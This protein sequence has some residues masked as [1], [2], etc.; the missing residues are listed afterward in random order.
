MMKR[1][2]KI[3]VIAGL[4]SVISAM[5]AHADDISGYKY[6][7][8]TRLI[9]GLWIMNGYEDGSFRPEKDI[10]R[11]E[12]VTLLMRTLGWDGEYSGGNSFSDMNGHWADGYV[13]Q[14]NMLGVANGNGDGTF[15]P[16]AKVSCREAV[17]F[18]VN[19]LGYSELAEQRGGYPD[20]YMSIGTELGLLKDIQ[21]GHES[22]VTRGEVTKILSNALKARTLEM[23]SIS[24]DK[25]SYAKGSTLLEC[26]GYTIRKGTVTSVWGGSIDGTSLGEKD[27]IVIDGKKYKTS[28]DDLLSYLGMYV[29]AYIYDEGGDSEQIRYIQDNGHNKK[30][31][32][33]SDDIEKVTFG[34]S[35]EYT[36]SERDKKLKIS[37]SFVVIK[38][39]E[40]LRSSG[41]NPNVFG[42]NE[43]RIDFIDSNGDNVYDIA[44]AW[45]WDEYVVSRL[46]GSKIYCEYNKLVDLSDLKDDVELTVLYDGKAIEVSD[47]KIGDVIAVSENSD[48]TKIKIEVT[49]NKK[50]GKITATGADNNGARANT[51]YFTIGSDGYDENV[52]FSYYYDTE[53]SN[54]H[55]YFKKP[56]IGDSGVLYLNSRGEIA[57][58]AVG[59]ELDPED[60]EAKAP[61]KA[62]TKYKYGYLNQIS[63]KEIKEILYIELLTQDN[64]FVTFEVNEKLQLGSYKGGSYA[65]RK[66]EVADIG[67]ITPQLVKYCLDEEGKLKELC[68]S[69]NGT[70]SSVWGSAESVKTREFANFQL[71]QQYVVDATTICF[72]IP[73]NSE[74]D[75]WKAAK[76]VT[77]LKSGSSYRVSLFDINDGNVGIVL[78]QPTLATTRY[79][80]ILDY[81]N[82]PVMLIDKVSTKYD[83]NEGATVKVISGW[84]S[85]QYKEVAVSNTLENNSADADKLR[86]GMLIQYLVNS[87][88]RSFARNRDLSE[89]M[90]LFNVIC[91]FKDLDDEFVMW[92]YSSLSDNNARIKVYKGVVSFIDN[93]TFYVPVGGETY[94]AALHGGTSVYIYKQ[95]GD[96]SVEKAEIDD[97]AIGSSVVV[98]QR[99]N[100]TREVFII[101]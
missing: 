4:I 8:D 67:N 83:E 78:Y 41:M 54:E 35:V 92:D 87:E 50:Y 6:E 46:N 70:N 43:G 30:V 93:D 96:G 21:A 9:V 71:E 98:R 26:I 14:A 22:P 17:T 18:L 31:S 80:Y 39:G 59:A 82:S 15:I 97:I 85:G 89:E 64:E 86:K 28:A 60:G 5:V 27:E 53:Y 37:D 51:K 90:I 47:L 33:Y 16:D 88:M 72:Y 48:K 81:V 58:F 3:A 20:G 56:D 79:K 91:D 95:G 52:F 55:S 94:V 62:L 7:K 101:E 40:M 76:A 77:M 66:T 24:P 12:F 69:E 100:N 34:D 25:V 68:L 38:N 29:E 73:V 11:A 75:S 45:S 1:I 74:D 44:I 63:L 36:E 19:S 10:T 61:E 23:T 99:Y 57:L 65:I 13:S 2:I 84:Q 32:I 49:R 42:F